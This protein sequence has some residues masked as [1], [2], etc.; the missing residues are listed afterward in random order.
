M[1]PCRDLLNQ[2]AVHPPGELGAIPLHG[3]G[4]EGVAWVKRE[5]SVRAVRNVLGH[6]RGGREHMA[7]EICVWGFGNEICICMKSD[8]RFLLTGKL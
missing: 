4:V 3:V 7:G 1:R 2:S 5:N 6:P 8:D